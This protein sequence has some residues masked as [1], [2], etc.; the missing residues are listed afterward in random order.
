MSR[1][2]KKLIEQN[3][4]QHPPVKIFSDFAEMSALAVRNSVD[5]DKYEE[6]E[7]RYLHLIGQ[8]EKD[9]QKRFGE[10]FSELV[11]EM[12]Q[13]PRDVLGDLFMDMG[14]VPASFL[15]RCPFAT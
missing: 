7:K 12:E 14:F 9:E 8:Y 4:C 13:N 1:N 15:R 6:R 2:L 10:M 3:A 11:N 5:V